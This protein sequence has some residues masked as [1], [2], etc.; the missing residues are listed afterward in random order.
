[1]KH[2]MYNSNSSKYYYFVLKIK[3]SSQFVS[4]IDRFLQSETSLNFSNFDKQDFVEIQNFDGHD[5]IM[6]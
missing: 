3:F 1:M 5:V 6:S 4:F 2:A